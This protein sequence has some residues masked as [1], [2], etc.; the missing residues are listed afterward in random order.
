MRVK[1][2][3]ENKVKAYTLNGIPV[4]VGPWYLQLYQDSGTVEVDDCHDPWNIPRASKETNDTSSPTGTTQVIGPYGKTRLQVYLPHGDVNPKEVDIDASRMDLGTQ[5]KRGKRTS[6]TS[7]LTP[8]CR[9]KPGEEM[10]YR[11]GYLELFFCAPRDFPGRRYVEPTRWD[12]P[13]K[14]GLDTGARCC[15]Y[16]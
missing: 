12:S 4:K 10:S 14:T 6:L 15:G 11:G 5:I 9:R 16:E 3:R 13:P 7:R 8:Q 1:I 2:V